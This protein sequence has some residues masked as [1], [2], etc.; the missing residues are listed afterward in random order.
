MAYNDVDRYCSHPTLSAQRSRHY[1]PPLIDQEAHPLNNQLIRESLL[2]I[3][4]VADQYEEHD[5]D[6]E[7]HRR[8]EE[9]VVCKEQEGLGA[10]SALDGSDDPGCLQSCG[11]VRRG[12]EGDDL[13]E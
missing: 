5:E 11:A 13:G 6:V 12:L 9:E 2:P 8:R 7:V 4:K 10:V 3:H 1:E